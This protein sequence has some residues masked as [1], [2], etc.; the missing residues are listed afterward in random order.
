MP[1][2]GEIEGE[3]YHFL[4]REEFD[5]RV[6]AGEF[7]EYAE[8]H[9]N[10]YGTLKS[11]VINNLQN[12]IDVL[13]DIDTKGAAA[14]RACGDPFIIDALVD[15]FIM[16]PNLE[17]LRRRLMKRGTETD[18]QIATRLQNAATEME[19][20]REYKYTLISSSMEEDIEKFRAVM[21]AERYQSRRMFASHEIHRSG[22]GSIAA[23][24]AADLTSKLVKH[25]HAVFVVMT[26]SARQFVG[27]MTFQTLS[28]NPVTSG[29]FD[30]RESWRPTHIDLA[31][32]ADLFL[33][34]PATANVIA[35][36]ALGICDDALTSIALA[37]RAPVFYRP[38]DEW[39]N[40]AASRNTTECCHAKSTRR[41]I[42][43]S[44]GRNARVRIRRRRPPVE[45]RRDRREGRPN[46]APQAARGGWLHPI[47][48]KNQAKI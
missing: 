18:E 30:E 10:K 32:R 38:S 19:R 41:R 9:G 22:R 2:S 36:L 7:L 8:V 5:R 23:Y 24:K 3:D 15:V 28:K 47:R 13:I 39:K 43:R 1:R 6:S 31:D 4:S 29:V 45:C 44:R 40:V 20:W 48:R 33:V 26:E 14:I 46:L 34:A 25:G 37:T 35:K 21:R 17:E 16:P 42:Y 27:A 11:P 12:G